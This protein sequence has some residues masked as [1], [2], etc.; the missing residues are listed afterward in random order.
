MEPNR[1]S[2]EMAFRHYFNKNWETAV[3]GLPMAYV[4]EHEDTPERRYAREMLNKFNHL[5]EKA[6][7]AAERE[8]RKAAELN[9]FKQALA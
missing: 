3:K 4:Q 7:A 2:E 6:G 5:I 8:F 1:M 9:S